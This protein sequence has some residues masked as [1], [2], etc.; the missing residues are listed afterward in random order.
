MKKLLTI[1]ML[2]LSLVGCD[3][4]EPTTPGE[5]Q[6]DTNIEQDN[7]I[8]ET[9]TSTIHT[10]VSNEEITKEDDTDTSNNDL[11]QEDD[12]EDVVSEN[13]EVTE[14][15]E[16]VYLENNTEDIV[17]EDEVTT[18]E[19]EDATLTVYSADSD[20]SY[21]IIELESFENLYVGSNSIEENLTSLL[22]KLQTV[23]F[24]DKIELTLVS[25]EDTLATVNIS[26]EADFFQFTHGSTGGLITQMTL[27]ETILQRELDREWI[28]EVQFL[29]DNN[30]FEL[31]HINLLDSFK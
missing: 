22:E 26:T 28:T 6:N 5:P 11:L 14:N 27:V 2:S 20:G 30:N 12:T 25:I 19:V 10:N 29:V 17:T 3:S 23:Y 16:E 24:E 18:E 31:D 4:T 21:D 9:S 15:N 1:L 7:Q 13:I 8:E